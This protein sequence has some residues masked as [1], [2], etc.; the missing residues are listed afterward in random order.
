MRR[1][2]RIFLL[3]LCLAVT[4]V[5]RGQSPSAV[6]GPSRVDD[7]YQLLANGTLLGSFGK[8]PANG[9]SPVGYIERPRY[10]RL[11]RVQSPSTNGSDEGTQVLA[12]RV[13]MSPIWHGSPNSGGLRAAPF[14][15]EAR[16][17]DGGRAD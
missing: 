2:Q 12:F 8:F 6:Q 10:F 1:L 3:S 17:G 7:A 4:M 15:G 16:T 13:W 11:P 5:A 9:Q 14:L